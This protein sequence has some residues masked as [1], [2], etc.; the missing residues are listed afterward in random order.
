MLEEIK[1]VPPEK[2]E[3][4]EEASGG[5]EKI[6]QSVNL[7]KTSV[8]LKEKGA[9]QRPHPIDTWGGKGWKKSS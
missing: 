6:Q 9:V 3:R 2:R 7:E 4:G 8:Y 5:K 1:G